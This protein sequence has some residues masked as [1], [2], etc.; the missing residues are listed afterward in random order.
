MKW[1]TLI[2]QARDER[3]P[4]QKL[5]SATLSR[6]TQRVENHSRWEDFVAQVQ[7][8]RAKSTLVILDPT[9]P[10]FFEKDF[11]K[12]IITNPDLRSLKIL[13]LRQ[14][15]QDPYRLLEEEL[16]VDGTITTL[17]SSFHLDFV[18]NRLL[19]PQQQNRRL[20][21]RA[22]TEL[23]MEFGRAHES[24]R[25][26]TCSIDISVAGVFVK[27]SISLA[28]KTILNFAFQVPEMNHAIEC[29]G[30]VVHGRKNPQGLGLG[31][32]FENMLDNDR[33]KLYDFIYPKLLRCERRA[34]DRSIGL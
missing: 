29:Q 5:L 4:F 11:R 30:T 21:A 6:L 8:A 7:T 22:L 18:L 10:G 16:D 31:V 9:T 14:N 15:D 27:T 25:E 32:R 23:P 1:K 20:H 28:P 33:D 2:F 34:T 12:R 3:S 17:D 19:F 26:Q 13:L 24:R